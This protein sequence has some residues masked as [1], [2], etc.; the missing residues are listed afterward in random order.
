MLDLNEFVLWQNIDLSKLD[1]NLIM[2]LFLQ[3]FNLDNFRKIAFL[4]K[5]F[6]DGKKLYPFYDSI[7]GYPNH[8]PFILE[9]MKL[10]FEFY[11][12]E[13][14]VF[15]NLF[16]SIDLTKA[17][18]NDEEKIIEICNTRKQLEHKFELEYTTKIFSSDILNQL[19]KVSLN[20]IK[21]D[22]D[23]T[24]N[25]SLGKVRIG[26]DKD[27]NQIAVKVNPV[28]RKSDV[29]VLKSFLENQRSVP[30]H[31]NLVQ[32]YEVGLD[33]KRREGKR[34]EYAYFYSM[35][36]ADNL[37]NDNTYCPKSLANILAGGNKL[38]SSEAVYLLKE[39]AKG[40]KALHDFG[41]VHGKIRPEN[42]L[43]VDNVPKLSELTFVDNWANPFSFK[44]TILPS[45]QKSSLFIQSSVD[46]DIYALVICA[47]CAVTGN[48]ERMFPEMPFEILKT[49]EGKVL[50]KIFLKACS[51][52]KKNRYSS[53][54]KFFE[55]LEKID[56][57][58]ASIYF[59]K[60]YIPP[61]VEKVDAFTSILGED[62][63]SKLDNIKLKDYKVVKNF[64][65]AGGFGD[66]RIYEHELCDFRAI[67]RVNLNNPRAKQE[68]ESVVLYK[69]KAP[70]HPHLI[71]IFEVGCDS[72]IID[73]V[74]EH[75]FFYTMEAADN[76]FQLCY[77]DYKH[78][79]PVSLSP[80]KY[81]DKKCDLS[82]KKQK[83]NKPRE[84]YLGLC[85]DVLLKHLIE[86]ISALHYNGLVHRDIKP[87]N[88]VFVYGK[89]KISDIGLVT[90]I[91]A[92]D[93]LA[94]TE[95][96]LPPEYL[97][98]S[99]IN[100]QKLQGD[101][102][103]NDLFAAGVSVFCSFRVVN[104]FAEDIEKKTDE[105]IKVLEPNSKQQ[106][107]DLINYLKL[108]NKLCA[109]NPKDRFQSA[110][111]VLSEFPK[112]FI[113]YFESPS[114]LDEF[115]NV[116]LAQEQDAAYIELSR[117]VGEIPY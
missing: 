91:D 19:D 103:R 110:S 100:L 58:E 25:G 33:V 67:K 29:D 81:K 63:M 113:E 105:I 48:S 76:L 40:L 26:V 6:D 95:G 43:W 3:E 77:P 108:I 37:C 21:F 20:D 31:K 5:H 61:K 71:K 115:Y 22:E 62:I 104:D 38:S 30:T 69:E 9:H 49:A 112:D 10:A 87:E 55:G 36:K 96:Y 94:G 68:A 114:E 109:V 84:E 102:I 7:E 107:D 4:L 42:I 70:E 86:G 78:Y 93:S 53:V 54:D 45:E 46:N 28:W 66:V 56:I 14:E 98:E 51:K 18:D 41:K 57:S 82:Y 32:V 59:D 99:Y 64:R 73:G 80:L 72:E 34:Y 13:M 60:K 8:Y 23:Y 75:F 90:T 117:Y 1:D 24:V 12:D 44:D 47:Y 11:H 16:N 2:L 89:L 52:S 35:E 17:T 74:E 83:G 50:N 39:L 92:I 15:K 79:H 97:K 116:E 85:S 106:A 88:L 27:Q 101:A 65:G 111:E